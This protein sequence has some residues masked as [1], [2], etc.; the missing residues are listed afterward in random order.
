MKGP[1]SNN[2]NERRPFC[3]CGRGVFV[4]SQFHCS[5]IAVSLQFHR[6]FI[7]VSSQLNR[8]FIAMGRMANRD[9]SPQMTPAIYRHTVFA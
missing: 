5:F 2:G 8:N 1:G 3:A 6:S 4:S 7:A 9:Q